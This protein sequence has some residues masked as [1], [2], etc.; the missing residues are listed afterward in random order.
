MTTDNSEYTSV[1]IYVY[2]EVNVLSQNF[3]RYF[4]SNYLEGYF[5]SIAMNTNEIYW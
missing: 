3:I 5:K 1:R 2:R 4:S